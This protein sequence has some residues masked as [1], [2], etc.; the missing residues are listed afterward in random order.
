MLTRSNED[1][2]RSAL[3]LAN[4]IEIPSNFF[5]VLANISWSSLKICHRE[6]ERRRQQ[7]TTES[8]IR[9][10]IGAG[11]CVV[12]TDDAVATIVVNSYTFLVRLHSLLRFAE[13]I[14]QGYSS[15]AQCPVACGDGGVCELEFVS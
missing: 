7:S 3:K 4:A 11:I 10:Q 8:G 5:A 14:S 1:V 9:L 15:A 12:P 13:T 6:E 2:A